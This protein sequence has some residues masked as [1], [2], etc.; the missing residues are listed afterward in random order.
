MTMGLWQ[1]PLLDVR[2]VDFHRRC[3]SLFGAMFARPHNLRRRRLV[4]RAER[5]RGQDD[6]DA[7]D[8]ENDDDENN[9][10]EEEERA[11]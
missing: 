10:D 5:L 1:W 6:E 11:G 7:A 4:V 3:A 9:E 2:L 8:D